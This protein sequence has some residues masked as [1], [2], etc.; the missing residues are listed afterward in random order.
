MK[1]DKATLSDLSIFSTEG[2]TDVFE[3][4][5]RTTTHAGKAKLLRHLHTPPKTYADL[6]DTQ[7][8]IAY[9]MTNKQH[10]PSIITNGTL[11]MLSSFFEAADRTAPPPTGLAGTVNGYL[12]KWL[13]KREYFHIKFSLSHLSDFLRGCQQLAALVA[14]NNL[15]LLLQKELNTITDGLQHPLVAQLQALDGSQPFPVLARLQYRARRELK[16]TVYLLIDSYSRLDAWQSMATATVELGWVL[17]GLAPSFPLCLEA[18]ALC[19]PLLAQ[20][21]PY[22][23][24]LGAT[25]NF[26]VLTGA[27]MSG[28][29]TFMRSLGIGAFLAHLGMGVPAQ[30][31]RISFLEGIVTNMHVQDNIL[32]GE[33]YFFAE[34]QRMKQTALQLQQPIPHLALMDEL[35]KGTNVHDACECTKAVMEGMLLQKTH[36]IVLS[37]H[38]YEVARQFS[39]HSGLYFAY[40]VTHSADNGDFTFSYRLQEGISNDRIGYR[41]LLQEGVIAILGGNTPS[42][43]P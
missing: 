37:T 11:V 23:V 30:H 2:N 39:S 22:N 40:F 21:T 7:Q 31:M 34:V 32:R 16:N 33:S 9:W 13:N 42:L 28:K 8:T 4:I 27:N 38:L 10:W 15:P 1:N 17:P 29:T 18:T 35:F 5:N 19:H 24:D 6:C 26:M 14:N 12:Q 20:A 43:C 41:I 36:L 25:R 3:L